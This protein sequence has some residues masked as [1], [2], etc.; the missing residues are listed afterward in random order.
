MPYRVVIAG[1]TEK[2]TLCA[3]VLSKDARFE[4]AGTI[5]PKPKPIGRKQEITKNPLHLFAEKTNTPYVLVGKS[6]D[7]QIIVDI[8][9]KFSSTTPQSQ[10][11]SELQE[12][13]F[14]A[15]DFLLVVDFGYIIPKELLDWP[16]IAPLNIHPSKLP[17]WRGS[18]P[19]QFTILYGD[20]T[21]AVSLMIMDQGLDSGP[22]LS[23]YEF[24]VGA[25][26]DAGEYYRFAFELV[27]KHLGEDIAMFASGALEPKSQLQLEPQMRLQS[28]H[29][30]SALNPP[31]PTPIARKIQKQD[32]FVEWEVVLSALKGENT[33][34]KYQS[35]L[36]RQASKEIP[37]CA[38][39]IDNA[40]RAFTPWPHLWTIVKTNKGQ[41]RM[42]IL[43]T[44]I[45]DGKLALD[46]VQIEGQ[47]PAFWTQVK[48][49]VL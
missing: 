28:H 35:L 22:I 32:A 39:L 10:K 17:R 36:L 24:G 30:Q 33:S 2:T 48:N 12:S 4:I 6:V 29:Q 18:S 21:S 25:N 7:G 49:S 40:C 47:N 23:Q 1:S 31:S 13:N 43:K 15:P 45:A 19:G 9:N 8:K 26:W 14:K 34:K 20:K 37:N 42:K 16:T 3:E 27:N 5:T 44:S 38:T 46:R 41:V 11:K